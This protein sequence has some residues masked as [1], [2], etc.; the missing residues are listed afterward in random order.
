M[1]PYYKNAISSI[2]IISLLVVS[3]SLKLYSEEEYSI[4]QKKASFNMLSYNKYFEMFEKNISFNRESSLKHSTQT[5]ENK[6]NTS[7]V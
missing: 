2:I 1:N 7:I 5:R 4:L 6:T 3:H